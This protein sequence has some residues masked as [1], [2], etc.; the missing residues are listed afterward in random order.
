M[1]MLLSDLLRTLSLSDTTDFTEKIKTR[2]DNEIIIVNGNIISTNS[3]G[4]P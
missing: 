3:E 4:L 1:R 2:L